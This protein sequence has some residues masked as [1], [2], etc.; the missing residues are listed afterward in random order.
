MDNGLIFPYRRETDHTEP[1]DAKS[2][3]PAESSEEAWWS[4]RT[5]P[6]VSKQWGDAEG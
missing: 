2:L 1:G 5:E 3:K 6:V 4:A